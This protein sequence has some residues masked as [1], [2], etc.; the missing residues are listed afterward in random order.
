M[1]KRH[2]ATTELDAPR[3]RRCESS[4]LQQ[5]VCVCTEPQRL[6]RRITR[7]CGGLLV[8]R[9]ESRDGL[10]ANSSLFAIFLWRSLAQSHPEDY[11]HSNALSDRAA[12]G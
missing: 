1:T 5:G 7:F 12:Y 6:R 3:N 9:D 4:S 10:A 11:S 8:H 2:D